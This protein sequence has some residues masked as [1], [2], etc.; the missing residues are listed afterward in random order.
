MT[1]IQVTRNEVTVTAHVSYD[2]RG[3][4]AGWYA[5]YVIDGLVVDDSQ[6]VWHP[7]MPTRAGLE[8]KALRVARQHASQLAADNA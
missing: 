1:T 6:K 4:D 2:D 8:R 7:E 3:D 5:Q